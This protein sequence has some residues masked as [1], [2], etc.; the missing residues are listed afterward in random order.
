MRIYYYYGLDEHRR[1]NSQG[2][3]YTPA[4]LPA[5]LTFLGVSAKRCTAEMLPGLDAGD[6]LLIGADTLPAYPENAGAVITLGTGIGSQKAAAH[7]EKRVFAHLLYGSKRLPLFVPVEKPMFSGG[8]ILYEAETEDGTRLPAVVRCSRQRYGFCFDLAAS[9][10]FS[11]D[12]FQSGPAHGF[13]MG[14]VPNTRPLPEKYPTDTAYNDLLLGILENILRT[15]GTP[16]LGKLPPL[17]DG[18]VPDFAFCVSGDDDYTSASYNLRAAEVL[19]GL[20]IPYHINV[21]PG[22]DSFIITQEE[23]RQLQELGCEI[24][25]HADFTVQP[26]SEEGYLASADC[27]CRRFGRKSLTVTNHCFIQDG[28]TAERLRWVSACGLLADN[29][30]LGEID[31][32]DINAYNLSGF[33]FGTSFPRMVCDDAAHGNVPLSALEIPINYYEPR[34]SPPAGPYPA[35]EKITDYIDGAAENGRIAQFFLHPHY[36]GSALSEAPWGENVPW[37][38]A[39]LQCAK[40]HWEQKN[41]HPLLTSVDEIAR[42]WHARADARITETDKGWKISS[43]VPVVL[44][45]PFPTHFIQIDGTPT[46]V[47][48]KTICGEKRYLI[49]VPEGDH[50]VTGVIQ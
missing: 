24:A 9:I 47:C 15:L 36:L 18:R 2:L 11:E 21:M 38:I 30:K 4:Y 34:L 17:P 35:P 28:E 26:Y 27:F 33:A 7:R 3:D 44:E 23:D 46:A 19:C 43:E 5:L 32:N 31:S 29:S 20:G 10:W 41:Y 13:F 14:R 48:E 42:F 16:M 25:L 39:A 40:A 8:D 1:K 49:T 6:C 37:A 12:G 50:I 22:G 45:L